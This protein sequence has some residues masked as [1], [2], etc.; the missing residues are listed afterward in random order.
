MRVIGVV[1][2]LAGRAVHA[3]AGARERYRPVLAVAGARIEPGDAQSL[4]RAYLEHLG[5][6]ELYVADLDAILGGPPQSSCVAALA[7]LRLGRT[8]PQDLL[9]PAPEHHSAPH[10]D[11]ALSSPTRATGAVPLWLDV[12]VSSPDRAQQAL[13]L[14]ATHVV[15]GLETL[16]SYDALAAI[17][18]TVG[19][20]NV[21]FS[22][23]LREGEPIVASCGV[24][25]GGQAHHVAV[26]AVNA[27]VGALI[28]IDLARVGTSAGLDLEL[29]ARVRDAAPGL[30]LLAGGGVRGLEDLGRL[31]EAGC[32]GA[33]VATALLD[34][35]IGAA[36][37]AAARQL[38][39]HSPAAG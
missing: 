8:S 14:G 18:A 21:A 29:I 19:G 6:T 34:G 25:P 3:R 2:L 30:T 33:L 32:D 7:D 39:H 15:V 1:D 35:R 11:S 37:V 24:A 36:E 26:R 4:A 12:A 38:G 20:A 23:D 28:V 5:I 22:L 9:R 17:C 16:A 13:G 10:D 27:G 31:A